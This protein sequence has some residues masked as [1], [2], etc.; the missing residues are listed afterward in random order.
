GGIN[1]DRNYSSSSGLLRRRKSRQQGWRDTHIAITGPAV[2]G[3][4]QLFL[5]HWTSGDALVPRPVRDYF[6]RAAVSGDSLV[7]VLSAVGGDEDP[8]PI[9]TAYV[10]ALELAHERIWITQAYFA[11]DPEFLDL[12]KEA[13]RRGVDVRIAVAGKSDSALLLALSRRFYGGLLE[14]GVRIFE[15]EDTVLHAKTAVVDGV[16]STVGSSNLDYRSF[17]HNHEVNAVIV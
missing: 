9:R 12:M 2:D 8:S 5:D 13:A 7:R 15:S 4:Q 17:I 3:F 11:P 10:L 16:W 14:A 1:I 6:G